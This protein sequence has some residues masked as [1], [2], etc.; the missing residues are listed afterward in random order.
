MQMIKN[1]E[2]FSTFFIFGIFDFQHFLTSAFSFFCIFNF[3]KAVYLAEINVLKLFS[4]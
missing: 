2:F 1:V 3:S 4:F